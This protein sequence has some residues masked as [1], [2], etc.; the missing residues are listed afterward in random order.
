[1]A[2]TTFSGPISAGTVREGPS[3]NLGNVV[4]SQSF[5][6]GDLTDAGVG[7]LD[8]AAFIVPAGCQIVDIVV[9]QVVAAGTGT[10]TVSVGTASGG[11]ELMAGVATTAGGRFRGTATAA[12]Q[13]AWQIGTDDQTVY[14]RT[15]VGTDTLTAGRF[16]LTVN[17]VQK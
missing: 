8:A 10:T 11:A 9:D 4:L 17:Y 14:V 7:N 5:D 13:L 12:T 1:M 2:R 3:S 16:I 15:A 6:S